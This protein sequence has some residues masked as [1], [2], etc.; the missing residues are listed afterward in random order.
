MKSRESNF[1]V[2]NSN[3]SVCYYNPRFNYLDKNVA[4]IKLIR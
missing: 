2:G 3:P 1:E 4:S